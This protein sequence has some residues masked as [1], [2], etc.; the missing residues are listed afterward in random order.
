MAIQIKQYVEQVGSDPLDAVV[1]G[2]HHKAYLVANL[3]LQDSPEASAE[4]YKLSLAEVYGTIA[5]YHENKES[6]ESSIKEARKL[7]EK[8]GATTLGD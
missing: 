4:H 3:A 7:G 2:R 8:L 1:S 6:I 5:F